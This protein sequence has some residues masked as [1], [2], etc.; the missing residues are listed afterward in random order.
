MADVYIG[1]V[2][3]IPFARYPSRSVV[4]MGGEAALLAMRDAGIS[5]PEVSASIFANV[6]ASRLFGDVTVGQNVF[7]AVGISGVPVINVENACTSGSTAFIVGVNAIRAG[8]ADVV[9]VLGAEKMCVP[10]LG[11][12]NSGE[13]EVDTLL[14]LVTPA[15]FALRAHR[16]MHEYG[17]T[18][19]QLAAISVK[20]RRHAAANP[21]AQFRT[22]ITVEEVLASPMIADPLTRL[23]S[24]PI[25]DGAAA[26]VLFSEAAARRHGAKVRV[27]SA[28][29]CSGS[30]AAQPDL[31]NWETDSRAA[32]LAYEQA[33]LGP[34]ELDM[35]ECHDAFSISEILHYEALGLCRPGGGGALVESGET[36]IGG[37]IPVNPSGGLLSRGHPVGVTGVAQMIEVTLHLRGQA[38]ERQIADARV[39]LA[40]C[41]GG[42]KAGD[43]KSCTVA[44]MVN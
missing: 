31:A 38:G 37:R 16:H 24:C 34:E 10:Q 41:M 33:G 27:R 5:P 40:Q 8:V 11:L 29:L 39:G 43:T 12:L 9:M 30:Y 4:S 44:I 2:G 7:A 28:I 3:I 19:R 22:P 15:S 21:V 35:V 32:R 25:A 1:G 36:S 26:V 17:T 42:D 20:N 13:T 23:Q 6:L 18:P 14:G